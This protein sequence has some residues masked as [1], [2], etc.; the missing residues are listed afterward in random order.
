MPAVLWIIHTSHCEEFSIARK[1][2]EH[3]YL[4]KII[5]AP[6]K[7]VDC[8]VLCGLLLATGKRFL[9]VTFLKFHKMKF[10]TETLT[11]GNKIKSTFLAILLQTLE[12][13]SSDGRARLVKRAQRLLLII[14]ATI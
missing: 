10:R 2:K 4:T 14:P 12:R 1:K 11:S 7:T 3:F 6:I 9:I 8:C 5:T 13:N